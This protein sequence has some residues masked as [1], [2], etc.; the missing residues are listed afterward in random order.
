MFS[1]L[2]DWCSSV[3]FDLGPTDHFAINLLNHIVFY[4]GN[5]AIWLVNPV[6]VEYEDIRLGNTA[7]F[8]IAFGGLLVS[9]GF[10]LHALNVGIA[11]TAH[12]A[13]QPQVVHQAACRRARVINPAACAAGRE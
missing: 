12:E 4:G 9:K 1:P 11:C 3:G 8:T 2:S 7:F 10:S 6:S 5:A 13:F